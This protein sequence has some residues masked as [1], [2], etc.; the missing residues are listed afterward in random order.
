[1]VA[2]VTHPSPRALLKEF[3]KVTILNPFFAASSWLTRSEVRKFT[4]DCPIFNWFWTLRRKW[5]RIRR[6]L[7]F[8]PHSH[9]QQSRD[10]PSTLDI[11]HI[12][13]A[14]FPHQL[15]SET[16]ESVSRDW[17]FCVKWHPKIFPSF[18]GHVEQNKCFPNEC[19]SQQHT[20]LTS[21]WTKQ[22][23][24]LAL[25]HRCIFVC[26]VCHLLNI[27]QL[28]NGWTAPSNPWPQTP[29]ARAVE[30]L[31]HQHLQLPSQSHIMSTLLISLIE[32]L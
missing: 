24:I 32:N 3:L 4:N 17:V 25:H 23:V 20:S 14:K 13:I 7:T 8:T 30:T 26:R 21:P 27:H 6:G 2:G 9:L 29:R 19:N 1:M 31:E 11:Q 10:Y 18:T 15:F 28:P 12:T 22:L 5:T 16:T